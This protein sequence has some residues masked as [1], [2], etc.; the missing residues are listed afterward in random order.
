MK[1]IKQFETYIDEKN[2][3]ENSEILNNYKYKIGN[4]IKLHD[5]INI[6]K[7]TAIN[8]NDETQPYFITDWDRNVND[9]GYWTNDNKFEL[10]TD[11]E[12]DVNKYNL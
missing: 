2:M 10:V 6:F 5:N 4:H 8:T 3:D 11:F 1:Y 12:L 7:I 9:V